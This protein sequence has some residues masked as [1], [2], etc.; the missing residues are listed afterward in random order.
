MFL[1]GF[2]PPRSVSYRCSCSGGVAPAAQ[3]RVLPMLLLWKRGS[4]RP[5]LTKHSPWRKITKNVTR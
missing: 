3:E 1:P 5:T 4:C 2:L